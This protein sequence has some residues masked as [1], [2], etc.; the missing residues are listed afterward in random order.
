MQ[1]TIEFRYD[2]Q[3][4]LEPENDEELD[5]DDIRDHIAETFDGDELLC[6]GDEDLI[7]LH[8]HTNEPWLVLEYC[9]TKGEIYDIV[10]EDMDRQTRGLQ[11]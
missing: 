5:V 11:G 7:K 2:T 3:L 6:V 1:Q 9:R 4:L 10:V 8:F